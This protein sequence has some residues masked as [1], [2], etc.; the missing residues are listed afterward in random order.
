LLFECKRHG[1][2]HCCLTITEHIETEFKGN[3]CWLQQYPKTLGNANRRMLVEAEGV[4]TFRKT[5]T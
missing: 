4:E 2:E 5:S 1:D 3:V